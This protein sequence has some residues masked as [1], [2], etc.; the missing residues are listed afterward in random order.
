LPIILV[1]SRESN[2]KKIPLPKRAKWWLVLPEIK[3]LEKIGKK[4][5][6]REKILI[7]IKNA[8]DKIMKSRK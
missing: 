4:I 5:S 7:S 8:F 3:I 1:L 6:K 2:S